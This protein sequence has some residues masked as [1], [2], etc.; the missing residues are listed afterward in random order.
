MA[1]IWIWNFSFIRLYR[2]WITLATLLLMFTYLSICCINEQWSNWVFFLERG[3]LYSKE[4]ILHVLKMFLFCLLSSMC[5]YICIRQYTFGLN[6]HISVNSKQHC[7]C[8]TERKLKYISLL[9]V[10]KFVY[11][12]YLNVFHFIFNIKPAQQ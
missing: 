4:I 12:L 5:I 1:T 10:W 8:W 3:I 9:F 7:C 11:V 6:S 2:A